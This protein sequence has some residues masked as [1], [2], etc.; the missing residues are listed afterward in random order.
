MHLGDKHLHKLRGNRG[1]SNASWKKKVTILEIIFIP[2]SSPL[3]S[4]ALLGLSAGNTSGI[5]WFLLEYLPPLW[6]QVLVVLEAKIA[7]RPVCL[8]EL[9]VGTV[10]SLGK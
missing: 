7:A 3:E 2:R 9:R 4:S 6:I 8:N 10:Q 5:H 1:T